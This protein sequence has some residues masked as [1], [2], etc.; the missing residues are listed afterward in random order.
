[1]SAFLGP[2]HHWLF[3]K[4]CI[5]ESRAF[6]LAE[7]LAEDGLDTEALITGYGEKLQGADLE[8]I[9]GDASIHMFLTG[10]ITKT[11]VFEAQLVAAAGEG[12]FDKVLI[13]AEAHGKETAAKAI[14]TAGDAP[15][16]SQAIY[17][18]IHEH[19]LEGMPCDPGGEVNPISENELEYTHTTCNHIPNWEYTDASP[20]NMCSVT[21]AWLKGFVAGL[22]E[23]ADFTV[24]QT[25]ADGAG[26]CL[27]RLSLAAVKSEQ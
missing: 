17:K 19:Q 27:A 1:M 26:S 25:I 13:S 7:T 24:E 4:I 22:S 9:V 5:I 8:Q 6:A 18:F 16:S 11:E 15:D 23:G 20:K 10:L 14:E 12:R 3:S 21:N 2:I